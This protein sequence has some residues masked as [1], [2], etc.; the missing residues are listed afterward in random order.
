MNPAGGTSK[1]YTFD[2]VLN[3]SSSQVEVFSA[4]HLPEMIDSVLSGYHACVLAYGQTGSGKTFSMEGYDYH[5]RSEYR[6]RSKGVDTL[7]L[8]G[9]WP[10]IQR[11]GIDES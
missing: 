10:F 2:Q 3:S 7:V 5:V 1:E 9:Y 8:G 4:A 6:V 11:T